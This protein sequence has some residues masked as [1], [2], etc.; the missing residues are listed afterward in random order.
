MQVRHLLENLRIGR[1]L[2]TEQGNG[3]VQA[4]SCQGRFGN[5]NI[6]GFQ[7]PGLLPVDRQVP[8]GELEEPEQQGHQAEHHSR[9]HNDLVFQC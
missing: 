2:L 9:R 4:L 7:I 8:V 6:R 1:G 5:G 3:S